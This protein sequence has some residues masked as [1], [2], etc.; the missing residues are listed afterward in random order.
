MNIVEICEGKLKVSHK[1]IAKQTNNT[2]LLV[3]DL[4]TDNIDELEEFGY[5][6]FQE[7]NDLEVKEKQK[8]NP[9]YQAE[10]ICYLKEQQAI[11]LLNLMEN[12]EVIEQFKITLAKEFNKMRG[13]TMFKNKKLAHYKKTQLDEELTILEETS[14]KRKKKEEALRKAEEEDYN[15]RAETL[16]YT[17]NILWL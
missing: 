4:I 9:D 2:L 15:A 16:R 12:S 1:V 7:E 6:H 3:Q 13:Y 11:L 17:T 8:V 5:L 10:N 14:Y